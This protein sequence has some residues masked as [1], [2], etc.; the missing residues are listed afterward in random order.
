[1]VG[2]QVLFLV[3]QRLNVV[4][5]GGIARQEQQLT[6]HLLH[7]LVQ[8]RTFVEGGV[9]QNHDLSHTKSRTQLLLEPRLDK[10]AVTVALKREGRQHLTLTKCGCHRDAAGAMAQAHSETTLS[11]GTPAISVAQRVIHSGFID[12]N[13]I[14]YGHL[15]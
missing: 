3:P 14:C 4:Q 2:N 10:R 15:G 1:V 13:P 12:V 8:L 6:S 11:F 9:V 7:Q 5:I